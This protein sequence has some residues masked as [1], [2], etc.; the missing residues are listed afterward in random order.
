MFRSGIRIFLRVRISRNEKMQD[1]SFGHSLCSASDMDQPGSCPSARR[2]INLHVVGQSFCRRGCLLPIPLD[3]LRDGT[4]RCRPAVHLGDEL[5][6][7]IRNG[8]AATVKVARLREG[9]NEVC[10][11]QPITWPLF[12]A[13]AS[14]PLHFP[15]HRVHIP[16]R[17]V[18]PPILSLLCRTIPAV[19][20]FGQHVRVPAVARD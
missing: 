10:I 12:V 4:V 18:V 17:E 14:Y 15:V 11:A 20:H 1:I 6:L 16:C 5:V 2:T 7:T 9:K 3:E 8:A 13:L 19:K